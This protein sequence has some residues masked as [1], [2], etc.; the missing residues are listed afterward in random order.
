MEIIGVHTPETA[1]ERVTAN[2]EKKIADL[3]ITYPVLVETG[4]ENWKRWN[5]RYWPTVWL[6]DRK[7]MARY[8]WQ[9]ELEY[10]GA[11]G[12]ARMTELIEKLLREKP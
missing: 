8:R 5:Q 4:G 2:V 9:G 12:E 11:G 7:G 10:K 6:I 1:A 3:K